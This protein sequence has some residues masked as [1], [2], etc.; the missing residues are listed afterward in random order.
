MTA[1]SSL[2]LQPSEYADYGVPQATT[3]QVRAATKLIDAH[4]AR[5]EGLIYQTD[6]AGNPC[7]MVAPTP[8]FT[9]TAGAAISPGSS[10]VLPYAGARLDNNSI[11]EVLVLD[12]TDDTLVEACV[13]QGLTPAVDGNPATITLQTINNSHASGCTMDVGLSICEEFELPDDRSIA[14]MSR[15]QAISLQSGIG[16]YGYG[17][18]SQQITGDFQ[19]FNLLAAVSSFGGPPLWI[20]W[21]VDNASVN[22]RTGEVWVPAGVLLAYFTDVRIWYV[23]GFTQVNLPENVKQACANIIL[24]GKETGLGANIRSRGVMNGI[25]VSKWENNMIDANTRDILKEY[26]LRRFI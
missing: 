6:A 23:A 7:Y 10:V 8:K 13:I 12:R 11:G 24:L 18:R 26:N 3:V 4:L 19:E 9:L 14:R 5:P 2:Y 22:Y 1:P 20:P 17:R 16:R 21:S 15:P 25:T